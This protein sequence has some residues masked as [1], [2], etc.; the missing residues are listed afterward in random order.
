MM[1]ESDIKK[2]LIPQMDV[3][4]EDGGAGHLRLSNAKLHFK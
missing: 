1:S 3:M 2:H 4:E